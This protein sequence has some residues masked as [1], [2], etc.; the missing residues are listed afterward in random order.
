[1]EDNNGIG[2]Y[3]VTFKGLK[4]LSKH[5]KEGKREMFEKYIGEKDFINILF[6]R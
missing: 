2:S 3:R 5:L 6:Q 4:Y 1:M